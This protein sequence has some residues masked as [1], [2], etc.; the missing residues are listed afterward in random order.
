[1]HEPAGPA[2]LVWL[3]STGLARAMR[4]WLWLYPAVEIA[5]IAG[6]VVLVGGIV[7]L[8]LR[9]L[10]VSPALPLHPLAHHVLPW[11]LGALLLVVPSGLLM[12]AAHATEFASN[13][14]FGLKM[15]LLVAAGAN[16]LVF[17]R[18]AYRRREQWARRPSA[19]A[20]AAGALSL[21]IWAGVIACG[22]LLAYV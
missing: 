19:A 12:F 11:S 6:L 2:V 16:A 4:E 8:D 7:V 22:R 9:L 1:M 20:R 15:L 3:E 14:V 13:P 10:G 5:H 21:A 17:H 18:G